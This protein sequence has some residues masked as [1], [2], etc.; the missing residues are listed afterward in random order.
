MPERKLLAKNDSDENDTDENDT[1]C[2]KSK[3][4]CSKE[5]IYMETVEMQ[6]QAIY[7]KD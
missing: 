1:S 7:K 4:W 3:P 5:E 2:S 6:N